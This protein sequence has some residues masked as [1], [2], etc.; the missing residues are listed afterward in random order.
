[1]RAVLQVLPQREEASM[2]LRLLADELLMNL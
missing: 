1:L 2:H